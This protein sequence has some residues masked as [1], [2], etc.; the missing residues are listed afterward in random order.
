MNSKEIQKVPS[1][2]KVADFSGR[3]VL[4]RVDFNVPIER[5]RVVENY[6]LKAALPTIKYIIEHNGRVVLVSHL[7]RPGGRYNKKYSLQP[8][9]LELRKLLPKYKVKFWPEKIDKITKKDLT[10]IEVGEVILLENLRFYPGEDKNQVNFAKK[11]ASFADFYVNEA[12]SFSHRQAASID[13]VP[14]FIPSYV[15]FKFLEEISQLGKLI[16]PKRPAIGIIGGLKIA[17][18]LPLMEK[19]LPSYN[20]FLVGGV[21]ANVFLAAQ[22]YE[23][24]KSLIDHGHIGDAKAMLKKFANKIILPKD[25]MLGGE[26]NSI[27]VS[28][29]ITKDK[30]IVYKKD[31]MILDIGPKT[32]RN[33]SKYIK[34]AK[35]IVW[36]GPMGKME[37]KRFSKGTFELA[38]M[39]AK[40]SKGAA[41]GAVG[42]G[43]TIEALGRIKMLADMDFVSTGGGAMLDF[44]IDHKKFPGLAAVLRKRK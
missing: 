12:F 25:V 17:T 13:G 3:I 38:K 19:L 36:N 35:T 11:L 9:Y 4:V 24:G 42:G 16:K 28:R 1:V 39:V 40:K 23:I 21:A 2:E 30:D 31:Q 18:K 44:L 10:T 14:N 26:V 37:D 6:R 43:E 8:V 20:Y 29:S 27:A 15:G 22:G 7:A 34:Q 33:F 5:G 32:I 41:Y